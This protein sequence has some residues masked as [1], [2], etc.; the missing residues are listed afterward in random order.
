[1]HLPGEFVL[2]AVGHQISKDEEN[3]R[4]A[5]PQVFRLPRLEASTDKQN[6]L[7]KTSPALALARK[8][9]RDDLTKELAADFE[10]Y[11]IGSSDPTKGLSAK[12]AH[13]HAYI[14]RG[15]YDLLLQQLS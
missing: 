9:L 8:K 11:R 13:E 1:D 14:L 3:Y 5:I 7:E 15:R 10:K 4:A 2:E 12:Q 6:R